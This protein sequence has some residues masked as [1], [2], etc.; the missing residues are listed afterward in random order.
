MLCVLCVSTTRG[1]LVTVQS[2]TQEQMDALTQ[3]VNLVAASDHSGSA[4]MT[5]GTIEA[6]MSRVVD[7]ES[8]FLVTVP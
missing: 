6:T 2:Q 8:E 3:A 7:I 1:T 4:R 5:L